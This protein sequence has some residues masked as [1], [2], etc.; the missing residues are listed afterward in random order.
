MSIGVIAIGRNEGDRLR[1]CLSSL[2]GRGLPVVY[3]DSKSTDGSPELARSMGAEVVALDMSIPFCA[4]RARNEGFDRLMRIAPGTDLVQ[5]VDGDCEVAPG[6]LDRAKGELEARPEAAAVCGRRRERHP[7]ASI[8]N[9]LADLEWNTP[10]GEARS[11]GGD[12]L[13][14][15]AAFRQAG[16]FD[17]TVAAGE[18]PELCQRMRENGWKIYRIDAE[19]TVHDSAM[20]HFSQWWKRAVRSGYGAMDVATRFRRGEQGLFVD[21][22]RRARKWAVVWPLAVAGTWVVALAA[23]SLLAP[24]GGHNGALALIMATLAA[25][26]VFAAAP[27][28]I[29]RSAIKA[30]PRAGS[31]RVA[32]AAGVLTL[33]SKWANYA[34]QRRYVQDRA[35]GRNTR[36][37]D[38]KVLG[39]VA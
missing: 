5:F 1:Q 28:Q 38:Y 7:Q 34:G 8:Y 11:V 26:I 21:Q 30:R 16:G 29:I 39:K 35:A 33:I 13:M 3:V 4:A 6:W 24:G 15:V 32:M 37:I 36:L 27:L 2:L 25:A 12:S 14:R 23:G 22:V 19:M 10:I 18:E 20:L 31:W 17:A 9:R